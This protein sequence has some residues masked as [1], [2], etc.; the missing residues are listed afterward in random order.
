MTPTT[1]QE[2]DLERGI[3][4]EDHAPTPVY[5]GHSIISHLLE[6]K[7]LLESAEKRGESPSAHCNRKKRKN[8]MG[9]SSEEGY[10]SSFVLIERVFKTTS[11][12]GG[13]AAKGG[14]KKTGSRSIAIGLFTRHR[15]RLKKKSALCRWF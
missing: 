8:H 11:G 5:E 13:R 9:E 12:Q 15:L 10:A 1:F 4:E 7:E 14:E 6:S 2:R 3:G